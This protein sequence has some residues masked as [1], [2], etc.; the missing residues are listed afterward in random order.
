MGG[1]FNTHGVDE[2]CIQYFW[3]EDVKGRGHLEDLGGDGK[4]IL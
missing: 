3:L 1:A 2:K 4:I